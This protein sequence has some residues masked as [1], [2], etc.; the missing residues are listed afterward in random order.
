MVKAGDPATGALDGAT[1]QKASNENE[2]SID[3]QAAVGTSAD[4]ANLEQVVIPRGG[5][6][7]VKQ[8]DGINRVESVAASAGKGHTYS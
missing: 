3:Q 6:C 4:L 7:D 1:F 2:P 8:P 5:Y